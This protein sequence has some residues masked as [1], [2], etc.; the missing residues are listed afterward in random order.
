MRVDGKTNEHKTALELL[1]NLVLNGCVIV[2]D[3]A[4]CQR[5]LSEAIVAEGGDYFFAVKD[6]QPTLRREIEHEFMAAHAAFSPL[7]SA[8]TR[9]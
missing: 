7:S 4:F 5:D 2:A 9:A 6:N 3:A 1:K 8:A